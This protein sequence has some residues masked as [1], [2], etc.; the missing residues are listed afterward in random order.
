MHG[1]CRVS[2]KS[3]PITRCGKITILAIKEQGISEQARRLNDLMRLES[4]EQRHTHFTND[5]G[6]EE[7]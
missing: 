1:I 3:S 5:T 6:V 4:L 2:I 7:S